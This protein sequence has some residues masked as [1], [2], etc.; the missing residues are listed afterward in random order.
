M[1]EPFKTYYDEV[2]SKATELA[3]GAK[4]HDYNSG[5]ITIRDYAR[6]SGSRHF[7]DMCYHKVLR[8]I[9]LDGVSPRCEGIEDSLVDLI[10]YA[11]F[12][13]A[14]YK[15]REDDKNGKK[16]LSSK[17]HVQGATRAEGR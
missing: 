4:S 3:L 10:N 2:I 11:A 14:E 12:A 9:S 13:Y 15:C 7:V 16:V 17:G 8:L 6:Y 1:I 5:D